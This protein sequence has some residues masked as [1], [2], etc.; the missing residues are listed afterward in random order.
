MLCP[1]TVICVC[2]RNRLENISA[3]QHTAPNQKIKGKPI[4]VKVKGKKH[5]R[6]PRLEVKTQLMEEC[7]VALIVNYKE[8]WSGTLSCGLVTRRNHM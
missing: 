7:K 2:V 4:K 1:V 8:R 6:T 3:N 5:I